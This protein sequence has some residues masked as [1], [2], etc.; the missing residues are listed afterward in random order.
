[1][2]IHYDCCLW[3]LTNVRTRFLLKELQTC[4][5]LHPAFYR[6][7]SCA[8]AKIWQEKFIQLASYSAESGIITISLFCFYGSKIIPD[9]LKSNYIM[10]NSTDYP[11]LS[12]KDQERQKCNN[13]LNENRHA[14]L[15]SIVYRSTA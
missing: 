14:A 5:S 15:N 12:N 13:T 8:N 9:L 10:Y 7:T 1:M 2:C 11:F 4:F 3:N 6:G